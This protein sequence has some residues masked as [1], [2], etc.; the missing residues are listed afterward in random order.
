MSDESPVRPRGVA[1]FVERLCMLAVISAFVATMIQ[2]V[3]AGYLVQPF[4]YDTTDT[5]MDWFNTA[6]W[7]AHEAGAGAYEVWR[8]IYPPISFLFLSL[9]TFGS[10]YV[11]DSE[12]ARDC[13]WL[14]LTAMHLSYVADVLIVGLAYWKWDRQTAP[15][16][17]IAI[18]FCF[19]LLHAWER[20]NI[21]MVAFVPFFL[22]FAPLLKSARLKWLM[23]ACAI[24]FKVY[25]ITSLVAP[26]VK[27][28]YV[29]LEAILILTA[30]VYFFTYAW[31]G[32]GL[33][34]EIVEN[35]MIFSS[36]FDGGS[37][38]QVYAASSLNSMYQL[39]HENGPLLKFIDS[40][41]VEWVLIVL[42]MVVTIGQLSC[43]GAFVAA[44]LRPASAPVYRLVGLATAFAIMTTES[45]GY[46]PFLVLAFVFFERWEGKL[47]I[48]ALL[49]AYGECLLADYVLSY[50][51]NA[52]RFSWYAGHDVQSH[53]GVAVGQFLRPTGL[54]AIAF[55][56]G[57]RTILDCAKSIRKDLAAGRPL[58]PTP[59]D[60]RVAAE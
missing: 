29:A 37:W 5:H 48:A 49:I 19:P 24:N 56:L 27:R 14:G 2:S 7:G 41:L 4:I 52:V 1:L 58:L 8:S 6:W 53:F 40:D 30:L 21:I 16:R 38:Q 20:G 33:P 44:W 35:I 9:T 10:C 13:D 39:F 42:P 51:T 57:L 22:G 11:A 28:R 46:T 60:P 34:Q 23:V 18:A 31:Y 47:R 36:N 26:F 17:T 43:I 15:M 59:F 50:V 25:F 55:C 32:K 12:F 54:I 3:E 45:G